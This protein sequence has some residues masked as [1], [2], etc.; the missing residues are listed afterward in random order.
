PVSVARRGNFL[1]MTQRN[2]TFY[3]SDAREALRLVVASKQSLKAALEPVKDWLE[4][5]DLAGICTDKGVSHGLGLFMAGGGG[6]ASS[7]TRSRTGCFQ[8]ASPAHKKTVRLF[9]CGVST[10]KNPAGRPPPPVHSHP[11]G[12]YPKWIAKAD[13]ADDSVLKM[14]PDASKFGVAVARIS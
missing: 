7:D 6:A 13:P 4:Q 11:E 5:Q 14:F 2:G 3:E 10:N 1:L 8:P 9:P 12:D